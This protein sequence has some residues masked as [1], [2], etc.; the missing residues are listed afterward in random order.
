MQALSPTPDK[1]TLLE[2]IITNTRALA[3][4]IDVP[5]LLENLDY[6]LGGAYEFICE[7]SFIAEVLERTNTDM[8]LDI[9]HARVSASHFGVSIK[10]YLAELPMVRV[11][12]LHI[13]GPRLDGETLRDAHEPLQAEDYELLE[14]VLSVT[15]PWVVTLEY[16]KEERALLE[17]LNMSNQ[18]ILKLPKH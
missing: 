9:A 10:E 15:K 17:Q 13:S 18:V 3:E 16:N 6:N 12:Q 5:L 14:Y 2:T 11:K 4:S 1:K 7:P 8:L